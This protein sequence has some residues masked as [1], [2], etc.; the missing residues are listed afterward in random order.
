MRT[1]GGEQ[2]RHGLLL[3]NDV[4]KRYVLNNWLRTVKLIVVINHALFVANNDLS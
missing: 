3:I 2:I 4:C 1:A